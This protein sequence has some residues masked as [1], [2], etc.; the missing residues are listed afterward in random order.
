VGVETIDGGIWEAGAGW[1]EDRMKKE[2]VHAMG[3]M[4]ET[5]CGLRRYS[6]LDPRNPIVQS[7]AYSTVTCP[8]CIRI[9]HRAPS[10]KQEGQH[11]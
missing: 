4:A 11:K 3:V 6:G 7:P 10:S 5:E 1:G 9:E 2:L 8:E